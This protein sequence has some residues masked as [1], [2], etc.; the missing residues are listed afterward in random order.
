MGTFSRPPPRL[1]DTGS[2]AVFTQDNQGLAASAWVKV[3]SGAAGRSEG[4]SARLGE[5]EGGEAPV[6]ILF[7]PVAR[8][9][10]SS[11]AEPEWAG[12]MGMRAGSVTT[13]WA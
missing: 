12:T 6:G 1:E 11:R 8:R 2:L 10:E 4:V 5:D 7:S 13:I 9:S 3:E